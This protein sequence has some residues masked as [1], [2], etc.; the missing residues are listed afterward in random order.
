[1]ATQQRAVKKIGNYR[2]YKVDGWG[3]YEIYSGKKSDGIHVDNIANA[4]NFEWAID[5]I[6]AQHE[7]EM[8]IEFGIK[9][10][11]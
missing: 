1:M 8:E 10:V 9:K 5:E 7:R 11:L 3:H 4:E 6:N 2:L